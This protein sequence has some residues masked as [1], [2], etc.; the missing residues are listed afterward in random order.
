LERCLLKPAEILGYVNAF[1]ESRESKVILVGEEGWLAENDKEAHYGIIKEKVVGKT[2][3]ITE[4]IEDI[5]GSLIQ[6]INYPITFD[7]IERNKSQVICIFK[8]VATET[9]SYNYRALKHSLR[10][11][12]YFFGFVESKY[13]DNTVFV[14][15]LFSIFLSLNYALQLGHCKIDTMTFAPSRDKEPASKE[16]TKIPFETILKRHGIAYSTWA[17]EL[18]GLIFPLSLWKDIFSNCH[19]NK[20]II[21]KAISNTKY[22]IAKSHSEWRKL[23]YWQA[24]SDSEADDALEKVKVKISN[25]EYTEMDEI[26]HVYAI[27]LGLAKLR[28]IPNTETDVITDARRYLEKSGN[29]Q[30]MLVFS[31]FA[32]N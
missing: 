12:E 7:I 21:S 25:A 10:D 4:T 28:A 8:K 26:L 17:P 6:K 2:F 13:R 20:E 19:V 11:F 15:E 27:L 5:I 9:E 24:L 3:K 30:I 1:V 23:W 31:V 29:H 16:R 22:F 18:G 32:K 14:N